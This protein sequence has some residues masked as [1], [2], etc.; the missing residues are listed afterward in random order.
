MPKGLKD[1]NHSLFMKP[2]FILLLFCFYSISSNAQRKVN[3]NAQRKDRNDE[4]AFLAFFGT[5]RKAVGRNAQKELPGMLNYPFYTNKDELSNGKYAPSDP[6]SAAQ[7]SKYRKAL[8]HADVIRFLP[9]VTGDEL[10]EIDLKT[11]DSYYLALQKLCDPKSKLYEA[12][13]Q[14][15]SKGSFA[16]SYFAFVFG[17]VKGKYKAIAYYAKWPVISP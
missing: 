14:Y 5:F 8:F 11:D 10:G 7:Y 6:L 4:S 13:L 3:S 15:P 12:Y 9:G 2:I 17:K 16:E 1:Q